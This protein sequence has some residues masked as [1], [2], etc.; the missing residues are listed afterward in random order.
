MK[1][2]GIWAR[3]LYSLLALLLLCFGLGAGMLWVRSYWVRD[4]LIWQSGWIRTYSPEVLRYRM[5]ILS[6]DHGELRC[7]RVEKSDNTPAPYPVEKSSD[8]DVGW[9]YA[10]TQPS[11]SARAKSLW[12][13][14]GFGFRSNG[15]SEW[16]FISERWLLWIPHWFVCFLTMLVVGPLLFLRHKQGR[17]A[18]RRAAN[19]CNVCGYDLRA[20]ADRCPECGTMPD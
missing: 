5:I 8:Q 1:N 12:N 19:L 3:R 4:E 9:H 20:S 16:G 10:S 11:T 14:L 2:Q 15:T 6:S 13:R 7:Y 18:A 17:I